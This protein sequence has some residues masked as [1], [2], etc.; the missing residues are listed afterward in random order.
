MTPALAAAATPPAYVMGVTTHDVPDG[1]DGYV[2]EFGLVRS[3]DTRGGAEDWEDGDIL[4]VSGTTAGAMTKVTPLAPIPKI[5]IAAVTN[6]AT[7]GNIFVRPTFG[8]SLAGL[9][10]VRITSPQNGQ[11]LKYNASGGYW[12]NTAP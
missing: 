6:A 4:Y 11:V 9:H 2:T 10:D 1:T 12:Y 7:N 8:E 3:V 5:M